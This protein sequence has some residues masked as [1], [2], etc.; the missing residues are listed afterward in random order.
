MSRSYRKPIATEGYGSKTKRIRKRH[1]NK[2]VKQAAEISNGKAYRKVYNSWNI[3]DYKF[4]LE[5]TK[6]N[7]R[8]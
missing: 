1:A 5:D 6:K 2:A 8:K 4:K 3:C 7:R